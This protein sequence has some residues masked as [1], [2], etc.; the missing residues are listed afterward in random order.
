MRKTLRQKDRIWTKLWKG[1]GHHRRGSFPAV[2]SSDRTQQ[3]WTGSI[4]RRTA[5][6][7]PVISIICL[8]SQLILPPFSFINTFLHFF[9]GVPERKKSLAYI[10]C[11]KITIYPLL[12]FLSHK[13]EMDSLGNGIAQLIIPVRY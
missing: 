7:R 1:D 3:P 5:S 2:C 12:L 13:S 6:T 10:L 11:R 8:M 9:H 4:K